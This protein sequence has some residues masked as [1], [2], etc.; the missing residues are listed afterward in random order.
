MTAKICGVQREVNVFLTQ[1]ANERALCD[2]PAALEVFS[3]AANDIETATEASRKRFDVFADQWSK[4][5]EIVSGA[6][7]AVVKRLVFK[8]AGLNGGRMAE[9]IYRDSHVILDAANEAVDQLKFVQGIC[10]LDKVDV[11]IP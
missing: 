8:R 4:M 2:N 3:N 1:L 5:V 7:Q 6:P 10:H 11:L 9:M